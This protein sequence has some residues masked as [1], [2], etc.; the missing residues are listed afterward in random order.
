MHFHNQNSI[1]NTCFFKFNLFIQSGLLNDLQ[2]EMYWM[3]HTLNNNQL[4]RL[5]RDRDTNNT[6]ARIKKMKW[7][8]N[9]KNS[10]NV[11]AYK[12]VLCRLKMGSQKRT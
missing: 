4:T 9:E 10:K 7:N 6:S 12:S 2:M 1:P 8:E 11:T 3:D 5:M